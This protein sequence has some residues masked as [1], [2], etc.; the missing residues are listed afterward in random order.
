VGRVKKRQLE[1]RMVL[2]E[3]EDRMRLYIL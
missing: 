1:K 3:M 2:E